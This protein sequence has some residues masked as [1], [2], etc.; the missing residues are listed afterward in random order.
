MNFSSA[1]SLRLIFGKQ[2]IVTT[3]RRQNDRD[4]WRVEGTIPN[5]NENPQN[6]PISLELINS[7]S[8]LVDWVTFGCFTYWKEDVSLRR[9][10]ME[11]EE[12]MSPLW[13][14][15]QNSAHP[16]DFKSQSVHKNQ[17][18]VN[19]DPIHLCER[20]TRPEHHPPSRLLRKRE[21]NAYGPEKFLKPEFVASVDK[22]EENFSAEEFR[23]GRRLVRFTRFR[24]GNRLQIFCEAILPKEYGKKQTVVSCIYRA[25]FGYFA[26]SYDIVS[27]MQ[28]L[29]QCTFIHEEKA[30]VRG[31]FDNR[32]SIVVTKDDEEHKDFYHQVM[33]FPPPTPRQIETRLRLV[34]WSTLHATLEKIIA[35]IHRFTVLMKVP[36]SA[37]SVL[38]CD[39]SLDSERIIFDNIPGDSR[40]RALK[41]YVLPDAELVSSKTEPLH[42]LR[43]GRELDFDELDVELDPLLPSY[44][45][46]SPDVDVEP[47]FEDI[48]NYLDILNGD[49]HMPSGYNRLL[50]IFRI[51]GTCQFCCLH[52]YSLI[53]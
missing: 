11:L 21:V 12:S 16:L 46:L 34:R 9:M 13:L 32:R 6:V 18:L 4:L 53:Q 41:P 25:G 31:M 28:Y 3:V 2:P 51:S 36:K 8:E 17:G 5:Q 14:S 40:S 45:T 47:F 20:Q 42:S 7:A 24:L 37:P 38:D 23:A 1:Y 43:S 29:L 33:N 15:P 30:R 39:C 19:P 52:S 27:L 22:M 35:F 10:E 44:E 50:W 26:S 48:D 49:Y